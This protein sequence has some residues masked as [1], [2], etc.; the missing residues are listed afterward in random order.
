MA[1]DQPDVRQETK[2]SQAQEP[3]LVQQSTVAALLQETEQDNL[4][5]VVDV[6]DVQ[7]VRTLPPRDEATLSSSDI[8]FRKMM[9]VVNQYSETDIRSIEDP[10]WRALV[11]GACSGAV[12]PAVYRAF[13][14]L[15]A[16][17]IP[18]R[19]AGRMIFKKV[20]QVMKN[21]RKRHAFQIQKVLASITTNNMSIPDIESSRF[22]FL[23][24]ADYNQN[25]GDTVLNL[26]QLVET[27]VA[28]TVVE[29]LGYE[30]FDD[31][32]Q[33]IHADKK[34]ELKFDECMVALQQ[35][36]VGSG[37]GGGGGALECNPALVLEEIAKR[38]KSTSL[39]ES[40]TMTTT[41]SVC[42]RKKIHAQKYMKMVESFV[43]WEKYIPEGKGRR[44]D[45]LRGC[46]VGARNPKVVEALKIV[47]MDYSAL[48]M[49]GDTVYSLVSKLISP[50]PSKY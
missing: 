33:N 7:H 11:E 39:A 4:P 6:D 34:G 25:D 32:I 8:E 1:M 10:R 15:F 38:M 37:T 41:T 19:I 42:E 30:D 21:S 2:Q 3:V 17:L 46:F 29:L 47:Y 28:T 45:V 18:L 40:T 5:E 27:G 9:H 20:D 12:E 44:L 24:I 23:S 43:E 26:D 36:P 13:E 48:R 16:D 31:F 35:C 49:A 50:P 14:V 22:A